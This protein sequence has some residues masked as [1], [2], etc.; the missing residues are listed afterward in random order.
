MTDLGY[1]RDYSPVFGWLYDA[2]IT[3]RMATGEIHFPKDEVNPDPK[4]ILQGWKFHVSLQNQDAEQV[5][6]IILPI[7]QEL[8]LAHKLRQ[9]MKVAQANWNDQTQA[10][11]DIAVYI[12]D[13]DIERLADQFNLHRL[14]SPDV[15]LP[16]V[17]AM[18]IGLRMDE[19]L[20]VAHIQ[21]PQDLRLQWSHEGMGRDKV[22]GGT[23]G[24]GR[25]GYRM[26]GSNSSF[27]ALNGG[28]MR[29]NRAVYKPEEVE[30]TLNFRIGSP[31]ERLRSELLR[32]IASSWPD[33]TGANWLAGL[34]GMGAFLS[35]AWGVLLAHK[36][37][38]I[39]LLNHVKPFLVSTLG[40]SPIVA[41]LVVGIGIF[42]AFHLA[43][44]F[45]DKDPSKPWYLRTNA[46]S[47]EVLLM[48]VLTTAAA[49]GQIDV[50]GLA[51]FHQIINI[52]ATAAILLF[53]RRQR[54]TEAGRLVTQS[55]A[56][57]SA[58]AGVDSYNPSPELR[59]VR[60]TTYNR[61]LFE[62]LHQA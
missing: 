15:K 43:Q 14:A 42:W 37:E 51:Q 20:K 62:I 54:M 5:L 44:L 39:L 50:Q 7:L 56:R 38:T 28:L 2:E 47:P 46:F 4:E 13:S 49:L 10:G 27:L 16:E 31:R 19:A 30:G 61:N 34:P 6:K 22:F 29:D 36:V 58:V 57:E 25:I 48:T 45:W 59:D 23:L 26:G 55:A 18:F 35:V 11:K 1:T 24:S 33:S 41:A 8:G 12:M 17:V 53:G 60:D 21:A 3:R 32:I 9:S 40:L 52:L